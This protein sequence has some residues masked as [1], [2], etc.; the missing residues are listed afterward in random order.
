[1]QTLKSFKRGDTFAFYANLLNSVGEP[2]GG[3]AANL[4]CQVRD[5]QDALIATLTIT[6]TEVVGKYLFQASSTD[7]WPLGV[8]Y[9]DIEINEDGIISSS[10][11]IAIPIEKDVTRN[12]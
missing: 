10:E 6:A 12:G 8:L 11:T 5:S 7:L 9:T 4:S 3:D 2:Y 1:M